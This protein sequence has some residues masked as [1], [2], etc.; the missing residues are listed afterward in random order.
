MEPSR[1][2]Y[3][4]YRPEGQAPPAPR[5]IPDERPAA[6][7]PQPPWPPQAAYAAPPKPRKKRRVFMWVFFAIQVIFIIWIIAG[8]AS[9]APGPTAAQQAATQCAN[10]GWSP[11]FKSYADCVQHYGHVLSDAADTGKGLGVALIVVLWVV[12]DFFL[13]LGYGIYRLASRR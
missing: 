2:P 6:S 3:T 5:F 10:G 4:R 11:L 1:D 13:G 12:A 9:K 8:A 7:Q